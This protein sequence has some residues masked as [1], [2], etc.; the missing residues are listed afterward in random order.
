MTR[1]ARDAMTVV[2]GARR[3]AY[4][5]AAVLWLSAGLFVHPALAD[6]ISLDLGAALGFAILE[7]STG[8]TSLANASNAGIVRGNIGVNGSNLSDSGVPING[9][10]TTGT[11][12]TLNPNVAPNV[13][14]TITPNQAALTLAVN[15]AT[16]ASATFAALAPTLSNTSITGNTTINLAAGLNVVDLTT[17][18]LNLTTLTLNGPAGSEIILNDSGGVTLNSGHIVLT[19]GLTLNDV[20]FNLTG[21]AGLSTSGGLNNESTL[22]GIFLALD[23]PVALTPGALTGEIISGKNIGIASGGRV[24]ETPLPAALPLFATGLG[25]L[26]L[27]GWRRKRKAQGVCA[28]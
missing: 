21:T 15:A 3:V 19:G 20:V 14:G 2:S 23:A 13:T 9:N 5:T 18:N 8:N 26:G 22:A 1:H 10:V 16:S 27:L 7:T 17:V 4:A 12:A 6:T 11:A 25:G 28:S 24:S